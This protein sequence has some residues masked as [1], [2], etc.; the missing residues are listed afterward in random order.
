MIKNGCQSAI[1]NFLSAKCVV[2]YPCARP[3]ILFY[4]HGP[5]I[6]HCFRVTLISQNYSNSKWP[7]NVNQKYY[8]VYPHGQPYIISN[9]TIQFGFE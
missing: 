4:F 2:G 8:C 9:V 6:L 3:Y 5:Y 1:I 7:L